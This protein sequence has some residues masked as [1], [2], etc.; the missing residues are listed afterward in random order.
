MIRQ[1]LCNSYKHD[2]LAHQSEDVFKIALYTFHAALSKD[3]TAYTETHEVVGEGYEA[4]GQVLDGFTALLEGDTALLD[5]TTDPMWPASTISAR[6]ALI[7][8]DTQGQRAV[9]VLDFGETVVSKNGRFT[10][11]LPDATEESALIRITGTA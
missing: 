1:A 8:N 4:G 3:T 6:G 5:W 11:P 9:A 2:L 10:V 7:Y